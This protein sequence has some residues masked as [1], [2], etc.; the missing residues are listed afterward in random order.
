MA[1]TL[2]DV[3]AISRGDANIQCLVASD[4]LVVAVLAEVAV[5]APAS[6]FGDKAPAA[7]KYLAAHLL[8]MS[9]LPN[10]GKGSLTS[11]SVGGVSQSFSAPGVPVKSVLGI[12]QFGQAFLHMR[13]MVLVPALVVHPAC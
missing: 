3:K 7:Q 9:Y 5:H 4:A 8:A 2:D 10:V 11:E 6:I 13:S 12:T 1:I